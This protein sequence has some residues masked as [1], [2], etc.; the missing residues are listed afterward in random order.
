MKIITA[1]AVA[2]SILLSGCTGAEP[3]L[4]DA[5]PKAD[6]GNHPQDGSP[7]PDTGSPVASDSGVDVALVDGAEPHDAGLDAADAD[8]DASVCIVGTIECLDGQPVICQAD[9]VG[10]GL[11][12][13]N[14][15]CPFA[16]QFGTC[17]GICQ[18]ATVECAPAPAQ[19]PQV[20]DSQ[21]QWEPFGLPCSGSNGICLNGACSPGTAGVCSACTTDM[22]CEQSCPPV[23]LS[24]GGYGGSNCCD[25][26]SGVCYA[27][28]KA[29]CP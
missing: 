12:E 20:C 3:L 23:L 2:I 1:C 17:T 16:C 29:T 10:V 13:A 9:A 19:Q 18:P 11:W 8:A 7:D 28:T 26:G 25:I 5:E 22:Q 21:G 15:S 14:G 27:T 24:D 6:A 4:L